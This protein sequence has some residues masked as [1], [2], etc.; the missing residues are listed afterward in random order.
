M[1]NGAL[2]YRGLADLTLV[3]GQAPGLGRTAERPGIEVVVSRA[4]A[5][6]PVAVLINRQLIGVDLL[7]CPTL[8]RAS[9]VLPDGTVLAGAVQEIHEAGDYFEIAAGSTATQGERY[10]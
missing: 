4:S 1:S 8:T 6:A 10:A 7:K 3:Y 9:L 2:S 5:A